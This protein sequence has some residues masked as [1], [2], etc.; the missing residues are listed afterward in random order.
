MIKN[1]QESSLTEIQPNLTLNTAYRPYIE[2]P[3]SSGDA[4]RHSPLY[5][6]A[7]ILRNNR[8]IHTETVAHLYI[9]DLY[10]LSI[11]LVVLFIAPLPTRH[12]CSTGLHAPIIQMSYTPSSHE[13]L[14]HN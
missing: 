2:C 10:A 12:F 11:G 1:L 8:N 5:F 3:P 9:A 13:S 4:A 7:L 6:F 14:S